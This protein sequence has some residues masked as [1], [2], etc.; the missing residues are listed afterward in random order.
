MN[1]VSQRRRNAHYSTEDASV[2]RTGVF[3]FFRLVICMALIFCAFYFR[4]YPFYRGETVTE[5]IRGIISHNSDI[6]LPIG[7][8]RSFIAEKAGPLLLPDTGDSPVFNE[9]TPT[10]TVEQ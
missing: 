10:K 2:H 9:N 3:V 6:S 8:L 4:A 7:K 5:Y 1:E